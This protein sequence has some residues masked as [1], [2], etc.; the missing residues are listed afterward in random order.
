MSFKWIQHTFFGRE[1][2]FSKEGKGRGRVGEGS[3]KGRGR[4]GEG[5]GKGRGR[6]GEGSGKGR[7]RVGEGSGKVGEVQSKSHVFCQY[8]IAMLTAFFNN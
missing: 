1:A 6:V 3:G 4:V 5:S 7:G 8:L 2:T